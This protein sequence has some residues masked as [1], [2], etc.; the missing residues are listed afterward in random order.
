M[1]NSM[2]IQ[3]GCWSIASGDRR[4]REGSPWALVEKLHWSDAFLL[5]ADSLAWFPF[6]RCFWDAEI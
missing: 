5:L 6:E 1:G 4:G 3:K 2:G